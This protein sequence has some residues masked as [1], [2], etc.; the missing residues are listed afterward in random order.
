MDSEDKLRRWL[1]VIAV[2]MVILLVAPRFVWADTLDYHLYYSDA[3][4]AASAKTRWWVS[5]TLQDSITIGTFPLDTS[6]RLN[7]D[8]SYKL[9]HFWFFATETVMTENWVAGAAAPTYYHASFIVSGGYDSVTAT[10]LQN[11]ETPYATHS[12]TSFPTEQNW[13]LNGVDPFKIEF[14]WWDNG[15]ADYSEILIPGAGGSLPSPTTPGWVYLYVDVGEGRIDPSTGTM[16][17]KERV[18]LF[19]Q[20]VGSQGLHDTSWVIV[21]TLYKKKPDAAGRAIFTVPANTVLRPKGSFYE[22][23]W[24]AKD[25]GLYS[26]GTIRK[27]ILD[28]IPSSIN[29]LQTQEVR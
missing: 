21:P 5:G 10:I 25:R 4:G 11:F 23:T 29:V 3:S 8:Y 22:L 15:I 24:S 18:D 2:V 14:L 13:T 16:I 28:T 6:I 26:W 19:L 27:F 12:I 1:Y 17:P 7:D 9:E 20:L